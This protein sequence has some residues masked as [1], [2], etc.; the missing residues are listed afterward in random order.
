MLVAPRAPASD[1]RE[2][3]AQAVM[4]PEQHPLAHAIDAP[5][6]VAP[7]RAPET[8]ARD[9][10]TPATD[11]DQRIARADP[12]VAAASG[13]VQLDDPESQV[14]TAPPAVAVAPTDARPSADV[15]EIEGREVQSDAAREAARAELTAAAAR[16]RAEERQRRLERLTEG[17]VEAVP[18][19]HQASGRRGQAG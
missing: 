7:R 5:M 19:R 14:P 15:V 12:T 4:P 1:V 6:L 2:T 16:A 9:S 11:A 8:E 17:M 10:V 3:V 13:E 18:L